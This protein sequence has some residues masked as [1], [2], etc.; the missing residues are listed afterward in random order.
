MICGICAIKILL[1][2]FIRKKYNIDEFEM[3]NVFNM[4]NHLLTNMNYIVIQT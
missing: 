1:F 4:L 2:F 3:T